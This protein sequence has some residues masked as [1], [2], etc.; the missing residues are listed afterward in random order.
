MFLRDA[1]ATAG[2]LAFSAAL[3]PHDASAAAQDQSKTFDVVVIGG[4]PGGIAAAVTAARFSHKVALVEY[5]RHFGGMSTSGLGKSDIENRE[6]IRGFFA[7]FVGKV[8]ADYIDRYG[9][10]SENV[11][12]CRDGYFYEPSVAERIFDGMIAE[13]KSL[14]TFRAHQLATVEKTGERVTSVQIRERATG[15]VQRL[16]GKIFVDATYE[17]DLYAGAGAEF[18][19]G[20][21]GRSDFGEPHA[22]HVYFEHKKAE[23]LPGGTGAGDSRLP[24]YTYRL[25]LTDNPDNAYRLTAAPADYDRRTYLGY[26]EDAR[27]GRFGVDVDTTR[28]PFTISK[29]PNRKTD[30]NMKPISLGFVFSEENAGYVEANWEERERICERIR[31]L[32]LGLLWFLQT[33]S[34]IPAAHRTFAS[35]LHLPLDEFKDTDHFPFQLYVREA[36]RLVGEYI[37]T[38]HDVTKSPDGKHTRRHADAIAVGEFPIDSFPVRK[39]QPGDTQILEGYLGMVKSITRPYQI[40]YRI[41][42]PR[43]VEGLIVPVAASTTHVAFSTIRME[44]TWMALG[45][46]AGVAAHVALDHAVEPRQVP[47]GEVQMILRRQGQVLDLPPGS[48]E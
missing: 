13:Q 42:I 44:P 4:T 31:R 37:L 8:R 27:S 14:A 36:R 32:T 25:C 43:R 41:M 11:T 17:G 46:A 34:E 7:E 38:E 21:E 20:R 12:L 47:M 1:T 18:K 9:R 30:V 5:H 15:K 33:D 45:Q 16:T 10:D 19:V 22:G 26:L 39:R 29:I 23:F 2:A 6:M 24:A 48:D 28:V 3:G 40:P 35:T